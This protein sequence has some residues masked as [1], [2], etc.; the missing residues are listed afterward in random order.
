MR[1][2]ILAAAAI[3]A[4]LAG[5]GAVDAKPPLDYQP[6]PAAPPA[7]GKIEGPADSRLDV[8][9]PA[10]FVG[11][12]PFE[13]LPS[14]DE[15]R[16]VVVA[17]RDIPYWKAGKLDP[18]LTNACRL[19]DFASL[20]LNPMVVRFTAKEGRGLLQIVPPTHRHLLLDRRR[21]ALPRQ[22]YY[23]RDAGLPS[24]QVWV[25]AKSRVRA[26]DPQRGTSLPPADPKALSKRKALIDSWP[27][28][29]P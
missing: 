10:P 26:L 8:H 5:G 9:I 13:N 29:A 2:V 28:A 16:W 20:P 7:S 23:F 24:C 3:A 4:T 21:L 6:P 22:T 27:K 14:I 25:D 1:R 17:V 19:G 12:G 15:N 11:P 18:L